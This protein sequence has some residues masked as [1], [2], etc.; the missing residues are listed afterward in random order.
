MYSLH[1]YI[2]NLCINVNSI[3]L[4]SV[5]DVILQRKYIIVSMLLQYLNN[6]NYCVLDY[7][8]IIIQLFQTIE[9]QASKT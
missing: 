9:P 3:I 4:T 8:I 2:P 7:K 6:I 1:P 5:F